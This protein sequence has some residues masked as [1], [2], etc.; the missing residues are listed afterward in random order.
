M[1]PV[2]ANWT[3][4]MTDAIGWANMIGSQD[5]PPMLL[6]L[7]VSHTSQSSRAGQSWAHN[8]MW[9]TNIRYP[10][11]SYSDLIIIKPKP[12]ALYKYADMDM[13]PA[14]SM[15]RYKPEHPEKHKYAKDFDI[16]DNQGTVQGDL[17]S[18]VLANGSDL[19]IAGIEPLPRDAGRARGVTFSDES[20]E[21]VGSSDM[22]VPP[23]K[24]S[25]SLDNGN[26]WQKIV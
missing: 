22:P 17:V 26:T 25:Y 19:K 1:L 18:T 16:V 20:F 5:D 14:S 8:D 12:D 9:Y 21:I 10:D 3:W 11:R 4:S 24:I 7:D 6:A 2:V 15:R 23:E 13:Y